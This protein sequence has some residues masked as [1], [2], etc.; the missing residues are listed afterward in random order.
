MTSRHGLAARVTGS[1]RQLVKLST[2]SSSPRPGK[3]TGSA[4]VRTPRPGCTYE[5]TSDQHDGRG[6]ISISCRDDLTQEVLPERRRTRCV[7]QKIPSRWFAPLLS[8]EKAPRQAGCHPQASRTLGCMGPVWP[9]DRIY[10]ARHGEKPLPTQLAHSLPPL[11]RPR[12]HLT[13]TIH[14]RHHHH[15]ASLEFRQQPRSEPTDEVPSYPKEELQ[16]ED[17]RDA[18]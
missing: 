3:V 14:D 16:R 15:A 17:V 6:T 8:E 13:A 12:G 2:G 9:T 11:T 10:R 7:E 1:I 18:S 4:A 5:A